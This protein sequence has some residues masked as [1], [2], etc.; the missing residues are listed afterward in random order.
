MAFTGNE[1]HRIS[2]TEAAKLTGNY[3]KQMSGNDI[4]GEFFGS[5]AIKELLNQDDCVGI[6][7]YNGLSDDGIPH[8]VLVSAKANENDIDSGLILEKGIPC[9][10]D[11]GETN[12]LNSDN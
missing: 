10:P 9:P 2:L 6:R 1:D 4:K 7:I 11:C 3:R 8:N 5:D 12:I